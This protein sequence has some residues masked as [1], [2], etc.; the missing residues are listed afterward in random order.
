VKRIAFAAA[1]LCLSA[2][3]VTCDETI[4]NQPPEVTIV[5]PSDGDTLARG[6]ITVKAVA[7]DDSGV[8][9][10]EFYVDDSIHNADYT[11]SEDTFDFVWNTAVLT[12]GSEHEIKARAFDIENLSADHSI[13]VR[14]A[15]G[16]GGGSGPTYHRG[17][18]EE[19]EVWD[20]AENP[21]VIEA[22]V[23]PTAGHKLTI[24]PGSWVEFETGTELRCGYGGNQGAIIAVGKPDSTIVFTSRS[25]SAAPGYWDNVGIYSAAMSETE[26]GYCLFEDGGRAGSELGMVYVDNVGLRMNDCTVQNSGDYGIVCRNGGFFTSFDDNTVTGCAAY[27]IRIDCDKVGTIGTGNILTGA[28]SGIEVVDGTVS[29]TGTWRNLGVAY[30]ISGDISVAGDNDPMLTIAPGCELKFAPEAELYCGFGDREGGIRAIGTP[31]S[32]IVFTA[33][34][35]AEARWDKIGAYRGTLDSTAFRHCWFEYGGRQGSGQGMMYID[36]AGVSID[37]CAFQSSGDYGIVCHGT[38]YFRSFT[39]NSIS[40][41]RL[42]PLRMG[43]QV[44]GTIGTGNSIQ[45]AGIE[46]LG[47]DIAESDTWPDIGIP[48][49]LDDDVSVGSSTSPKLVIAPGVLIRMRRNVEL[50]C[51]YNGLAGAIVADGTSERISFTSDQPTPARGDWR[52]VSFYQDATAESKLVNCNIEY[53]GYGGAEEF[54][55]VFIHSSVPVITGDSIGHG[56]GWGV[57]LTGSPIPDTSELRTSN[58]F[59]DNTRGSIGP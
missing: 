35:G 37:Q 27:Q 9:R 43:C 23:Y 59:Y 58:W 40:D 39:G 26:F 21:H 49:I 30:I 38:G 15:G 41:C 13:S 32:V 56:S 6:S 53:G 54:G 48:Y 3:L 55:N 18:I 16:G 24:L 29:S 42:Y 47:G 28:H 45:G 31:D 11:G 51:G 20:P 25:A 7:E 12:P 44:V 34:Q 22:D 36:Y 19:D 33:N 2:L 1:V 14:I 8:V 17:P 5:I 57:Y 52:S 50:R 46:V 4:T 10:V